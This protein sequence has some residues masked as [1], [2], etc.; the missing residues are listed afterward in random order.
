VDWA[1]AKPISGHDFQE[2]APSQ[3]QERQNGR[4]AEQQNGRIV[5]EGAIIFI[6][7]ENGGE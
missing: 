4:T 7:K 3:K 1:T 6:R 2:V 5:F